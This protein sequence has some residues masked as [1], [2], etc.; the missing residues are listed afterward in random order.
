HSRAS[1]R[2]KNHTHGGGDLD[3]NSGGREAAGLGVDAENDDV[4]GVLVGS[5]KPAAGWVD[6]E[7]AG[8][9]ALRAGVVDQSEPAGLP[10][11]PEDGDAVGAAAVG[12]VEEL[13]RRMNHDLGGGLVAGEALGKG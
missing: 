12:D 4:V 11:D 9:A 5:Q 13:A 1:L 2:H 8:S 10:V 7:P 3:V 6:P